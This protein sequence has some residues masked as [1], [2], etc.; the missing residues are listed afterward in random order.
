ESEVPAM[1]RGIIIDADDETVRS[2]HLSD[3][4]KELLQDYKLV[5]YDLS[6][7]KRYSQAEMF[8]P[9]TEPVSASDSAE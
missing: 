4:A 3:R 8:Y 5:Q 7:G 2:S 9:M 6:V 1:E